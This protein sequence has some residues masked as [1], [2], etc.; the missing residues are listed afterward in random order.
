MTHVK[1]TGKWFT[2]ET[3]IIFYVLSAFDLQML[4]LFAYSILVK[5][6][7]IRFVLVNHW[8]SYLNGPKTISSVFM[9]YAFYKVLVLVTLSMSNWCRRFNLLPAS[10]TVFQYLTPR[11][12]KFSSEWLSKSNAHYCN[13]MFKLI[14]VEHF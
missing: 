10:F 12:I 5:F 9:L 14:A 7:N 2:V 8:I 13:C 6:I 1:I 11:R 3:D 4:H